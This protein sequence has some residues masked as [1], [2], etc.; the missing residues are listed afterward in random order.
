MPPG[1]EPTLSPMPPRPH[2]SSHFKKAPRDHR[3]MLDGITHASKLQAKHW[4]ELQFLERCGKIKNLRREVN[5]PLIMADGTPIL[6]PTGM[7]MVYRVDHV[8]EENGETVYE[9]SKGFLTDAARI[10]I[11]VFEAIYKTK[12]R[13]VRK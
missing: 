1:N 12:V 4:Q 2:W 5:M 13:L 9:E 11:A 7:V 6:T 8:Y 10:K 3:V